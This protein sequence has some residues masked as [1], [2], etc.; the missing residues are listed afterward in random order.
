MGAGDGP[1][2]PE[3]GAV[4]D[5]EQLGGHPRVA[6]DDV[7]QLLGAHLRVGQGLLQLPEGLGHARQ[8]VDGSQQLLDLV[9]DPV[10]PDQAGI[11][12]HGLELL[13][14]AGLGHVLVGHAHALGHQL[15]VGVPGQDHPDRL[16][17]APPHLVQQLG[18]VH[19]RHAHVGH[20][21]VEGG[22]GHGGQGLFAAAHEGHVPLV[23]HGPEHPLQAL[24]DHGLVVNEQDG[25]LHAR[26]REGPT[27]A[28]G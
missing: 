7:A 27:E 28:G 1:A 23:P 17:V 19:A 21:H 10:T 8:V 12:D 13:R 16:G 14:V 6:L 11:A 2:Q 24:Q 18:A 9:R 20:H 4:D 15:L 5:L 22:R 25:L 3:K 26:S